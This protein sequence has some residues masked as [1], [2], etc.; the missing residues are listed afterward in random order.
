MPHQQRVGGFWG[1]GSPPKLTGPRKI[2]PGKPY[3]LRFRRRGVENLVCQH[4]FPEPSRVLGRPDESFGE[5]RGTSANFKA[6]QRRYGRGIKGY[7]E[8]VDAA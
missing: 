5:I 2:L 1:G 8:Q 6:P 7:C 4:V 3:V